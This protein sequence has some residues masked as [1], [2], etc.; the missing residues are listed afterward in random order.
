M[1][2]AGSG[3]TWTGSPKGVFQ[4]RKHH[5]PRLS[6]KNNTARV[7]ER[8]DANRTR[9]AGSRDEVEGV[10][11]NTLGLF[12]GGAVGFIDCLGLFTVRTAA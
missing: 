6:L 5:K 2:P 1:E 9:E 7:S 10:V 3:A 11:A 8:E 4:A 12:P